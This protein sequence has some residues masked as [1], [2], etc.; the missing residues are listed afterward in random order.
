M[1]VVR[2]LIITLLSLKAFAQETEEQKKYIDILSATIQESVSGKSLESFD[3]QIEDYIAAKLSRLQTRQAELHMA[4]ERL[5][6][7]AIIQEDQKLEQQ[8][9]Q[10]METL[11]FQTE[12]SV[13]SLKTE[14]NE[15]LD[16]LLAFF[17]DDSTFLQKLK[18]IK[19]TKTIFSS[20]FLA[21]YQ[22]EQSDKEQAFAITL[23]DLNDTRHFFAGISEDYRVFKTELESYVKLYRQDIESYKCDASPDCLPRAKKFATLN[24]MKARRLS[25]QQDASLTSPESLAYIFVEGWKSNL[26]GKKAELVKFLDQIS[27]LAKNLQDKQ[28]DFN[29]ALQ[30]LNDADMVPLLNCGALDQSNRIC[31]IF[32]PYLKNETLQ[33]YIKKYMKDFKNEYMKADSS[34]DFDARIGNRAED[35][36]VIQSSKEN[37]SEKWKDQLERD[38]TSETAA[39]KAIKEKLK[40]Y[41]TKYWSG[42]NKA[43]KEK[44]FFDRLRA[45]KGIKSSV[46]AVRLLPP[47]QT[48]NKAYNKFFKKIEIPKRKTIRLGVGE[49]PPLP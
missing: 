5:L 39:L 48:P 40:A 13:L 34:K 45:D 46:S 22:K 23:G 49:T 43:T 32:G 38:F 33:T 35:N 25:I 11:S 28:Q 30:T 19:F 10:L 7:E 8:Q 41:I 20:D 18:E 1:S 42:E 2:F 12:K 17:N 9:A 47:T 14:I 27:R 3:E 16:Q 26:E 21:E 37:A 31:L 6:N 15:L 4:E 44:A 24:W 36:I 29:Q